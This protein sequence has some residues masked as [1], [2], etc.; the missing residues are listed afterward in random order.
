MLGGLVGQHDSNKGLNFEANPCSD[1]VKNVNPNPARIKRKVNPIEPRIVDC[2]PGVRSRI[3]C[4]SHDGSQ[5]FQGLRLL[6][7]NDFCN[8]QHHLCQ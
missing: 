3:R 2:R 5:Y 7:R 4:N 1:L 6:N 8:V